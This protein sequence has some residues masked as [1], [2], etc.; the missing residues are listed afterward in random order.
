[1]ISGRLA[2]ICLVQVRFACRAH[3]MTL[4]AYVYV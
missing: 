4:E 3:R 2:C 1:M